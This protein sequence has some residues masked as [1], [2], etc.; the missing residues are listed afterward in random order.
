[1]IYEKNSSPSLKHPEIFFLSVFG[2]GLI[3]KAQGTVASLAVLPF[4]YFL[5]TLRLPLLFYLPFFLVT[6]I[7]SCQVANMA[8]K[9]FR[10]HDPSWIVLDEVLGM[11][12]AWF[13]S[14]KA[15]LLHLAV[16]FCLFRF[17]DIIKFWPA[18][19]FDQKINH[20]VGVILDDLVS[21]LYAGALYYSLVFFQILPEGPS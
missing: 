6:T 10:A 8:Q 11:T 15:N 17:F 19:F 4:L 14:L 9:K 3:P 12:L 5:A 13:F 20:G 2:I 1:M 16:L 21:G 18:N 7:L